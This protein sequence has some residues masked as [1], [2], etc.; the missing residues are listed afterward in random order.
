MFLDKPYAG[1]PYS[2]YELPSGAL[3]WR[4]LLGS[5]LTDN[6][7]TSWSVP[8]NGPYICAINPF[9]VTMDYKQIKEHNIICKGRVTLWQKHR[10]QRR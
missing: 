6:M 1:S 7:K 5:P 3:N 2:T 8:S 4:R 10:R 9:G